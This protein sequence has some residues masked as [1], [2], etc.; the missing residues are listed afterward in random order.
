MLLYSRVICGTT[1]SLLLRGDLLRRQQQAQFR[2]LKTQ[3][4]LHGHLHMFLTSENA[5]KWTYA[6]CTS[7]IV[8]FMTVRLI[9]NMIKRGIR[10]Q[11]K[12]H[13]GP[14]RTT[15]QYLFVPS[16]I[17]LLLRRP[18]IVRILDVTISFSPLSIVVKY[19]QLRWSLALYLYLPSRDTLAHHHR[20]RL[21][22]QIVY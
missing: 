21:L 19:I 4:Q 6:K 18:P 11:Q 15:S 14:A 9:Y 22:C 16:F 7:T 17:A 8:S 20:S 12:N 10:G 13:S 1:S 2:P 5:Q 3:R